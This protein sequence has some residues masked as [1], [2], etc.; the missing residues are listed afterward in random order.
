MDDVAL[1]A[2]VTSVASKTT[3]AGGAATGILG[4]LTSSTFFGLSGVAIAV[5]GLLVNL[6]FQRRRDR[7]EL[8]EHA[9]RM[10]EIEAGNEGRAK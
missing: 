6:Y 4:F 3:T 9:A 2:V 1:D 8:E 5:M 10:I 7:R